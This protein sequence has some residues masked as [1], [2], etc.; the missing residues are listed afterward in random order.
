MLQELFRIVMTR[1]DQV[2]KCFQRFSVK[3]MAC[4][5]FRMLPII[6]YIGINW[7]HLAKSK[8]G[9]HQN[10]YDLV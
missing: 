9:R 10:A 7:N 8:A 6:F 3:F 4:G 2:R 1:F 5:V